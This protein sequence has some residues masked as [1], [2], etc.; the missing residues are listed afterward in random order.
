MLLPDRIQVTDQ[1]DHSSKVEPG[2]PEFVGLPFG[3][4]GEELQKCK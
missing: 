3:S 1:S 4:M 2:E